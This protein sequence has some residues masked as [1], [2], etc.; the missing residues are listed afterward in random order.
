MSL[1]ESAALSD[2]PVVVPWT[3][4]RRY[5]ARLNRLSDDYPYTVT[6]C[7]FRAVVH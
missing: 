2:I 1:N 7:L 3:A 5:V 4:E 6:G